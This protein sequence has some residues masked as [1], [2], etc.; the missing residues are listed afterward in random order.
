MSERKSLEE[1]DVLSNFMLNAIANDPDVSKPFFQKVLSIL[2]EREIG[3]VTVHAQAFL[4]ADSPQHRGIFMDVE[5][6]EEDNSPA[7]C[8]IYSLEGQRY[9]EE[10]LQ[11]RSRFYQ[12]KKDSKGLKSGEKDW[13]NLPDL[14]MIII[15]NYDPFGEDSMVY[16]F[17]NVCEQF[18]E[19]P[20]NDGL[21]FI[22]FNTKGKKNSEKSIKELLDYLNC[23]RIE[24]VKNDD[25]KQLHNYVNDVKHRAEVRGHYMTWGEWIDH[26]LEEALAEKRAEMA[27]E[28][29]KLAAERKKLATEHEKITA[30][31][32]K[33]ATERK[34]MAAERKKMTAEHEKMTA[35]H[36]KIMAAEH[37]KMAT[38]RKKMTAEH[39]TNLRAVLL[40]S[41]SKFDSIDNTLTVKL[42][43]AALEELLKW[44]PIA[45]HATTLE[46][47]I[48]QIN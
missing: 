37:E 45:A 28:Y 9:Y 46:D 2:L 38:E 13:N 27:A 20:Y 29:E 17:K 14:Y 18:P 41:L 31:Y 40:S 42:Q 11:K 44:I 10:Y 21:K 30:E 16:I 23:S 7:S 4:P 39:L 24:N 6:I 12:A 43:T 3:E 34:K 5:I 1:L 15:T 8:S 35:E 26:E 47:F 33:M 22:Y 48:S 19:L 25:I 32:E 36:E